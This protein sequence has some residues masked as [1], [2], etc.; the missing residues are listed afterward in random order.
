MKKLV[1]SLLAIGAASSL[2]AGCSIVINESG[3]ET[4]GSFA[5]SKSHNTIKGSDKKVTQ[6]IDVTSVK[7]IVASYGVE[8]VYIQDSETSAEFSAPDN[9]IDFFRFKVSNGKLKIWREG[10]QNLS[11]TN[12]TCRPTLTIK[13][14]EIYSVDLSGASSFVSNSI[15]LKNQD[16]EVQLSGASSFAVEKMICKE[17]DLSLSG[18]SSAYISELEAELTKAS[19]SG[20]SGA[21]LVG[22]TSSVD[23]KCSGASNITANHLTSETGSVRASGAS[24]IKSNIKNV[25]YM[26]SSGMSRI[27]N[28]QNK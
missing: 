18:A 5:T 8:V 9:W 4:N 21:V 3:S 2:F 11:Y 6:K 16:F 19:C 17:L 12:S 20:A 1:A 13:S 10:R 25:T 14:P 15:D 24:N 27:S 26:E 7:S 23:F 22:H 28:K